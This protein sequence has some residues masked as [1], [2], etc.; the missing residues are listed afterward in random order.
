MKRAVAGLAVILA[1]S[2]AGAT[3][4]FHHEPEE[5]DLMND[6]E[7]LQEADSACFL[8]HHLSESPTTNELHDSIAA[9]YDYVSLVALIARNHHNGVMP[10]W[11]EELNTAGNEADCDRIA[12]QYRDQLRQPGPKPT[13]P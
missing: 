11:A 13:K 10:K 7:L 8:G 2:V 3:N 6:V 12:K 5:L 9:E 4:P 1:A